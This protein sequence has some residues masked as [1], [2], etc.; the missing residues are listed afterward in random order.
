MH[1]GAGKPEEKKNQANPTR[2]QAQNKL[3]FRDMLSVTTIEKEMMAP[4][5][6]RHRSLFYFREALFR[7]FGYTGSSATWAWWTWE[8]ALWRTRCPSRRYL[9]MRWKKYS[10]FQTS[11]VNAWLQEKANVLAISFMLIAFMKLVFGAYK[12]WNIFHC[13][14]SKAKASRT[15]VCWRCVLHGI[16]RLTLHSENQ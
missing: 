4:T 7:S 2:R 11:I 13:A 15:V 14:A 12:T 5:S 1:G 10:T 8:T 9:W 3:P 6:A 16:H